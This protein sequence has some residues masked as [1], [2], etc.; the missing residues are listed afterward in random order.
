MS[1]V[2]ILSGA[3]KAGPVVAVIGAGGIGFDVAEFLTS[4][5]QEVAAAP[6]HFRAEWGID[7]E[8]P[9]GVGSAGRPPRRPAAR[10]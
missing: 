10:W 4:A 7:T 5:P 1:Y 8:S 2:D 3:R 9:A 6:E